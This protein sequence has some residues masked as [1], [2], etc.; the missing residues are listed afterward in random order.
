MNKQTKVKLKGGLYSGIAFALGMAGF[1]FV[2]G[3]SFNV[4]KFIFNL[5][6]FG[7][8]MG[9]MTRYDFKK[10]TEEKDE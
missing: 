5:C 8:S 2:D 6:F 7:F 1:D 3:E 4:W 9:L 10:Q